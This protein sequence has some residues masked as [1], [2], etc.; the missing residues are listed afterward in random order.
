[1][2]TLWE[3]VEKLE[4]QVNELQAAGPAPARQPG[5]AA[6]AG[7]VDTSDD[8]RFYALNAL[9]Q[10]L[11]PPGGV[12]Y[13]GSVE[14][15][16]GQYD[17]QYAQTTDALL[18]ADWSEAADTIAALGNPIRLRLLQAVLNGVDSAADLAELDDMGSTGQV[19]HHLRTLVA[20]G[21]LHSAGRG[22]Y[23]VPA[24]RVVALL[25]VLLAA[26]R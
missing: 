22:R 23:E 1:M 2:A 15:S 9:K 24:T 16:S 6:E 13:T 3:R 10:Q 21:W 14:L 8:E 11:P 26:Q 18:A 17:W 12:L 25:N 19:Y 7:P 20:A 5:P 4:Q